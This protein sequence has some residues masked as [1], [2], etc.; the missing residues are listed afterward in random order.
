MKSKHVLAL[1]LR[2]SCRLICA[3]GLFITIV[4]G[5]LI[6]VLL[7]SGSRFVN[8]RVADVRVIPFDQI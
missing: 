2:V 8:M 3:R 5:A 1:L 7:E 6:Y 4:F